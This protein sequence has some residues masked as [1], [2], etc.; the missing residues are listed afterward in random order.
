MAPIGSRVHK[1]YNP[2][3]A[4][5]FH[6]AVNTLSQPPQSRQTVFGCLENCSAIRVK[7]WAYNRAA[8]QEP[9]EIVCRVDGKEV[10]R[11]EAGQYW[12]A[13]EKLG[14]GDGR[15]GFTLA[16][17]PELV[18]ARHHMVEVRAIAGNA[19]Y[20]LKRGSRL[21]YFDPAEAMQ[22]HVVIEY[23]GMVHGWAL[24]HA[25]TGE[26][27]T[28]CISTG[29]GH[30]M[31]VKA[32]QFRPDLAEQ[33]LGTGHHG[34]Q[35]ILPW[36]W[37]EAC[38]RDGALHVNVSFLETGTALAGSPLCLPI[39]ESYKAR[40]EAEDRFT[41][42]T[43]SPGPLISVVMP[44]Y[45][46]PEAYLVEAIESV[47]RQ[48]YSNWQLCIADD[49]SPNPAIR[50]V[51][52]Q[53]ADCDPRIRVV[54]RKENGNIS[55]ASNSA[56][57]LVE[58]GHFA[59]LDH[60]DLL[61][62][63]ALLHVA[64]AI[65]ANP[66]L[67]I[68]FSDEDKCTASGQRFGPY[69]KAGW[70]R[71]LLLGQ[72]CVSH[73]GVF[74]TEL[75]RKLGGFRVGYEGSQDYDLALRASR[76]LSDDQILHI[77]RVLYHWRAIPG[78]TALANSEKSYA[79]LAMRKALKD[80]LEAIGLEAEIHPVH[81]GVFCR[82]VPK[83][84]KP[85]PSLS[86]LWIVT[87]DTS[88][89]QATA[90]WNGLQWPNVQFVCAA[91]EGWLLPDAV[92][93]CLADPGNHLLRYDP[94]HLDIPEILERLLACASGTLTLCVSEALEPSMA[95]AAWLKELAAHAL[96]ED[97]GFVCAQVLPHAT[98]DRADDSAPAAASS[99]T[100]LNHQ[101]SVVEPGIFVSRATTL[102]HALTA[103]HLLP[104]LPW[105]QAAALA[106][107]QQG[108][109][110]IVLPHVMLE[111]G[112]AGGALPPAT[113]EWPWFSIILPTFNRK[114]LL[115]RAI[116][117][118][119]KQH[120][121]NFELIVVDDG[122]TDG[123]AE[124]IRTRYARE[125]AS[126]KLVYKALPR[127]SGVSKA[128]NEGLACARYPWIAYLDSDNHMRPGF[129]SLFANAIMKRPDKTAFYA[130]FQT[131]SGS[132]VVGKPFNY[133]ELQ[134]ANFIDLGVF[135]HAKTLSETLGGFDTD[136]KRLVD[137]DLILRFTKDNEPVHLPYIVLDYNDLPQNH[138]RITVGES[139]ERAQKAIFRKGLIGK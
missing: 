75:V 76:V 25:S 93:Y 55:R 130:H 41:E 5:R 15:Y 31:Q 3:V 139:F 70:D 30:T 49:A 91:P 26:A 66:G 124:M 28:V 32:N 108:R 42:A 96:R 8:P 77:P 137:W 1:A 11:G 100:T 21:H 90:L 72:N 138:T 79:R 132:P 6:I 117:S 86:V 50:A 74:Q 61:H 98:G 34:F 112:V 97:I 33:K 9:L 87:P 12:P 103:R 23:D 81:D 114:P 106:L 20:P 39:A 107:K 10:A 134:Q 52:Q 78:S 64:R 99:A 95:G 57:E 18:D 40:A 104:S 80:H 51:L 73:L 47:R 89:A 135:V 46:P 118:A 56:L 94:A 13:L 116:D 120:Y 127:Q 83:L 4:N 126:G 113:T 44:V 45:N 60:D 59:L 84:P 88:D 65:A 71:E 125:L 121:E 85:S 129:L 131:E 29:P 67:G 62:P 35:A 68:I 27:V 36:S 69:H 37:Y 17:P 38:A 82:A 43:P 128:R 115:V 101:I 7:G 24:N 22:G 136:L 122:S 111:I 109:R 14:M 16:L 2:C 92:Q 48:S 54:F 123:T 119:L 110:S 63:D 58:A 19:E 105:N 102:T 133:Q 53:Y